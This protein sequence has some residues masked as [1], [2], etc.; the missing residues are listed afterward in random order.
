M[1]SETKEKLKVVPRKR[2]NAFMTFR[3]TEEEDARIRA[4]AKSQNATISDV[5]LSALAQCGVI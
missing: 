3:I 4:F 1:E 5:V 2:P